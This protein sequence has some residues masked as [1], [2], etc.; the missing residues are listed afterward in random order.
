MSKAKDSCPEVELKGVP[1]WV[2]P[3]TDPM[4]AEEE[5]E[6]L[7]PGFQ[8]IEGFPGSTSQLIT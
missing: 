1:V 8:Q 6:P 5:T 2:L 3:E 4:Q 7:K